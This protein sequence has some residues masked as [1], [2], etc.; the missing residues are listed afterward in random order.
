MGLFISLSLPKSYM[1]ERVAV[2]RTVFPDIE[3]ERKIIEDAGMEF[4]VTDASSP[5]EIAD[6]AES[7]DGLLTAT[8][9]AIDDRVFENLNDLQVIGSYG[10]GLDHIDLDT[11]SR[12]DVAVSNVPDY[13][14]EEVSTHALALLLSA[15]RK[16]PLY[17]QHVKGGNWDWKVGTPISR[18]Q[19]STV[20][21]VALGKIGR[22]TAEKLG[23]FDV[24][25]IAYDPYVDQDEMAD[26]DVEK[27]DFESLL[28]RSDVISVHIP[29]T[30]E[31]EQM[32][33][34]AAFR[35]MKESAIFVHTSRGPVIS[36]NALVN[37]LSSGEIAGA[38]VDVLPQEPPDDSQLF[39]LD[40]VILTPHVAWYSEQS[41]QELQRKAAEEVV[42]GLSGEELR[43][44]VNGTADSR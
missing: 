5:E 3:L 33:D 12:H 10:I 26:Y 23:E 8:D 42:R 43:Y 30:D 31:T 1:S 22:R 18:L 9:I 39:E 24:D 16:I 2:T 38:G 15:V 25:I 6:R 7:V 17:D 21:I 41:R 29:L 40:N 34:E 37:A 20:G 11:A 28:Q 32:F 19:G 4:M 36:E 13:C 14:I 35:A 27:V 44:C